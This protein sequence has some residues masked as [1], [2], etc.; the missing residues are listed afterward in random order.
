M[1]LWRIQGL[2]LPHVHWRPT[3]LF[4]KVQPLGI[5][6]GTPK[7]EGKLPDL[8][9]RGVIG[10]GQLGTWPLVGETLLLWLWEPA[11]FVFPA[12]M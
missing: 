11:C 5:F 9:P 12:A 3:G 8:T 10:A 2:L 1:Q 6:Q 4:S 7:K